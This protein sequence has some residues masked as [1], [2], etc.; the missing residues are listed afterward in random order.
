MARK[1]VVGGAAAFVLALGASGAA[2]AQGSAPLPGAAGSVSAQE[3]EQ[4]F[5]KPAGPP[6]DYVAGNL[7]GPMMGG[8]RQRLYNQGVD[9]RLSYTGEFGGNITGQSTGFGYAHQFALST[10][11][12]WQRLAG[13]PGL[14]THVVLINRAGNNLSANYIGD[15]VTEA[16]EIYGGAYDMGVNLVYAYAEENLLGGRVN[17]AAGHWPVGTDFATSSFACFSLTLMPGCGHPRAL[18]NSTAFTNWPQSSFGG[19]VRGRFLSDFYAQAGLW[20]VVPVPGGGRSGFNWFQGNQTGVCVPIE[21]GWEPQFGAQRL[22]G[23]YKIGYGH[24]TSTYNNFFVPA[25][26]GILQPFGASGLP[27]G[28]SQGRDNF[29]IVMDQMVLRFGPAQ[30]Q[31]LILLAS[32]G[33]TSPSQTTFNTNTA[34][35]AIIASGFIRG[36]P[37][38]ILELN[39]GWF[40]ISKQVGDLQQLQLASGQPTFN[41]VRGPQR[42]EYVLELNY[43][44]AIW[45]G[46]SVEPAVEYFVYPNAQR[47]IKNA[48]VFAG[49]LQIN[50]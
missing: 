17:I 47:T 41:G 38:D 45:P 4:L 30:D 12:D 36:R 27:G 24:D 19:R 16:T 15:H 3:I 2:W 34:Y 28:T 50:F 26:T 43:T 44:A 13:V 20:E 48:L 40:G 29:W 7:F 46:V 23:H 21:L 37:Q 14:L 11:I 33:H 31:G 8:L 10:D 25:N 1:K 42:N 22:P 18:D 35:G 9:V 39:G 6:P 5:G 49:R 32:Y